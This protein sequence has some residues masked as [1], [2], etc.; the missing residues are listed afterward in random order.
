MNKNIICVIANGFA[1][2]IIASHLMSEMRN[3]LRELKK[4]HMYQFV[5]GSL[6]SSGKWYQEEKFPVFFAGGVTPS[7]GFPTKSL[8]GFLLDAESGAFA[9]PFCLSKKVKEWAKYSLCLTIV[10]GDVFLM[11]TSAGE[12]KKKHIPLVFIPTA[13]SDYI[14][15]HFRIEKMWIRKYANLVYTRDQITCDDFVNS[16]INAYYE[17]NLIQDLVNPQAEHIESNIPIVALFPGSRQEA[18]KNLKKIMTL[19]NQIEQPVHWALVKADSININEFTEIL[20]ED[21]WFEGSFQSDVF[22]FNKQERQ[23]VI[24]P[25]RLFDAVAVSCYFAIS[26]AGTAGEQVV[27]LGKPVIGFCGTGPQSTHWRML[28]NEKLLGDAFLYERKFPQGVVT[29]IYYLLNR[30]YEV[31][32]LGRIGLDRMG[33]TGATKKIA[34]KIISKYFL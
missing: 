33:Q 20:K 31:K 8:K 17:G 23:L 2:E 26:L 9:K 6:V 10:V 27:G 21:G 28:D 5:G 13:K 14:R 18:A 15:P 32:R 11:M 29:K 34:Q 22:I 30:S 16:G 25:N 1:E 12:L 19:V 3:S 4:E 24:Y 7:G